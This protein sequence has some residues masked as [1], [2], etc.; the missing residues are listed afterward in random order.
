MAKNFSLHKLFFFSP[1]N[2]SWAINILSEIWWHETKAVYASDINFERI[3][4]N[5]W[6][7]TFEIIVYL[8]LHKLI[9]RNFG[10]TVRFSRFLNKTYICQIETLIKIIRSKKIVNHI[11]YISLNY[12]PWL[13]T[14]RKLLFHLV[15]VF[16]LMHHKYSHF[17]WCTRSTHI[18]MIFHNQ[19]WNL[20]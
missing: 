8:T 14:K 4:F 9:G 5:H 19:I 12:R 16:F 13:L 3:R 6:H 2:I 1:W 20:F 11:N 17:F 7:N 18:I 15:L 10:H